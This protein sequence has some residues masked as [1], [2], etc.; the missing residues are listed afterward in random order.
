MYVNERTETRMFE[1]KMIT[2]TIRSNRPSEEAL[3][4]YAQTI[5]RI[6]RECEASGFTD[7]SGLTEK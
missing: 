5:V 3:K 6:V 7:Y 4:R 2:V 1:G